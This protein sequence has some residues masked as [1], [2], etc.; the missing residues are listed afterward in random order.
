MLCS[1]VMLARQQQLSVVA[2][3]CIVDNG[4]QKTPAHRCHVR[5]VHHSLDRSTPKNHIFPYISR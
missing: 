5:M 3:T 1:A 2:K 4:S